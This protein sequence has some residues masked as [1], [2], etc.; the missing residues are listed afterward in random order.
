[1]DSTSR[2]KS[3]D[4][5][6]YKTF[7]SK[8]EIAL[9]PKITVVVGPN[10]S[11][12][13]NIA[14]A[15]RWVLGE[16]SY[17]LL[18][19]KKTEDMI[20]TGS[21]T[22]PR[23]SMAS[24]SITF[25]NSD[26]WLP[27]DFVEV[28]ISRRAYRDGQNEYL[29][30]GQRVRLRD[31]TELLANSGLAQRTYTIIGQ[32]LV[33]VALSL[34]ADERRRLFEEAAGIGLYRSRREEALRR[35]DTTRR[36][37]ERVQ[38][39]LTEL[40]PRLR[41]LKR[42]AKRAGEY[43]QVKNDLD[44][45][46]R[47]WYGYHFYHLQEIVSGVRGEADGKA[48]ARDELRGK[49]ISVER[50]LA[51][52]RKLIDE[53]RTQ[54]HGWSRQISTLHGEREQHGRNL[55]VAQE[56][57]Q[58]LK[59]QEDLARS[60][61]V[62]IEHSQNNLIGRI[63]Q[64]AD[65]IEQKQTE[66]AQID[67][68]RSALFEGERADRPSRQA[69]LARAEKARASLEEL[70]AERAAW[71][72]QRAQ[73]G[74]R[75]SESESNIQQA[76]LEGERL[77]EASVDVRKQAEASAVRLTE[78]QAAHQEALET[79]VSAR[80]T[81]ERLEREHSQKQSRHGKL[82]AEQASI[83]A[84]QQVLRSR[85]DVIDDVVHQLREAVDAGHLKGLAGR[86]GEELQMS[87]EHQPAIVAALGDFGDG[88]AFDTVDDF[89]AA[90]MWMER[91]R[92]GEGVAFIALDH[93]ALTPPLV[94]PN[95]TGCVGNAASLVKTSARY[96]ALVDLLLGQTLVVD[97]RETALRVRSA[98][99]DHAR[100]V[101]LSG[102]V[103]YPGGG[104]LLAGDTTQK[105]THIAL[106][107]L[108]SSLRTISK[109]VDDEER[110]L[111]ES[112]QEIETARTRMVDAREVL[113]R[114][115]EAKH[116][117]ILEQ[118]QAERAA[119]EAELVADTAAELYARLQ[120]ENENGKKEFAQMADRAREFEESRAQLESELQSAVDGAEHA[121]PNLAAAKVE[122]RLEVARNAIIE[123]EKRRTA[124]AERLTELEGDLN[125]WTYRLDG[126][127]SEQQRIL[128]EADG[129]QGKLDEVESQ[130]SALTQQIE[131]AE[132]ELASAEDTRSKLEREESSARA[133]L[134]LA[135][136]QH[137]QAQIELAR[138]QEEMTSLHRRIEDDFGLVTFDD[139]PGIGGQEP[140]PFEGLV[141]RLPRIGQLPEG[142]SSQVNRL[143]AQLRRMGAVNPEAQR[144]FIEVQ[145]R[146]EFLTS[147][148]DDLRKAETQIQEVIAE[149]DLLMEREF[150]K[151]YDAVAVEF[152]E[153]FK[154]LF[155]GGSAR[156]VLTNPDDLTDTGID[157][158]ARLP[159][160]REQGLAVL[161]GGER[162]LTACALIFALLK[163]APT[164]FC[165]L[166]EVDAMLDEA[167]V[168]RFNEM[169]QELSEETQ[170]MVITH[171]RLTVQAAD[172]IYGVSMGA[173]SVSRIIG[174]KLDEA[175][176]EIAAA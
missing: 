70:A 116:T 64:A 146:V 127:L 108:D 75:L 31:V 29:L 74:E 67:V 39:I 155:G 142:L 48:K 96:Q 19:G 170:F 40:Q 61:L 109:E 63:T 103:F 17:S 8:T 138:R 46:L 12:K 21:E 58:G 174:L 50:E 38:D 145:D 57:L 53:S 143:R 168:L 123:A 147:Q 102:D 165:L 106:H 20:F 131:P 45:A 167:N 7:A 62:S 23:A 129:A 24:A 99:P 133:A 83:E 137:S 80:E 125:D 148:V 47:T 9:A 117:A 135:E 18:R 11:G 162:S 84:R 65:E 34:K 163:V 73:L 49:Q 4:L 101:T 33:D 68:S 112:A 81:F 44:S 28:S 14:D 136:H 157:I 1:M 88:L 22:R 158:E 37:L 13:S 110:S 87:G 77:Q 82:K 111:T 115:L 95:E 171:N 159:G 161:S 114:S 69:H 153:A 141:E 105:S 126:T 32:G 134:Q 54:L 66:L 118:Q 89:T 128:Q 52:I 59:D 5:Q 151:T 176:R 152:R 119:Q 25:D 97:N 71:D 92:S 175:E 15:I 86:L 41:S 60:E 140:L 149:F 2:V 124:L 10:G 91:E 139:E 93:R 3:V 100:L 166:D 130:L 169:L 94:A 72:T 79:D 154:R 160:R 6:G 36:N 113:E 42:Q 85:S 156:L 76:R 164:P 122:A 51:G 30:N 27:I 120:D 16:Q 107:G 90:L 150:R 172:V 56:R 55:A 98:L 132:G 173:D 43:E 144:E 78:A 35:L 104:V 121:E 26:G